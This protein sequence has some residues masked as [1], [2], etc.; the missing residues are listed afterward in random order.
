MDQK[1]R[2]SKT[3]WLSRTAASKFL[4][5]FVEENLL[6][7]LRLVGAYLSMRRIEYLLTKVGQ[8]KFCFY[9]LPLWRN[10]Q[11]T[12]LLERDFGKGLR[13]TE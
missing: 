5:Q 11:K 9:L 13:E 10:G 12:L 3:A 1:V 4:R 6:E 8:K 2:G 7:T